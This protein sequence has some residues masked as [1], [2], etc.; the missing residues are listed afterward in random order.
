MKMPHPMANSP[1]PPDPLDKIVRANLKGFRAETGQTQAESAELS[2]VSLDNLRRYESG[3]T[4]KVPGT[5]LQRLAQVYGHPIG[6]FFLTDPPPGQVDEAP[7][8]F[9]RTRPGVEVDE[10]IMNRLQKIIDDA[11][12]EARAK[13]K[14]K[15]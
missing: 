15:Q 5:V 10:G 2:G 9:L 14:R 12:K 11:N 7:A 8:I 4:A 1:T 6:D 3:E 13:R